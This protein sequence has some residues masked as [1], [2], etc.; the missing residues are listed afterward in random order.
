MMTQTEFMCELA[1]FSSKNGKSPTA[2][3][4]DEISLLDLVE[5]P[6]GFEKK[7]EDEGLKLQL[8][9]LDLYVVK[10][11]NKKHLRFVVD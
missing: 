1:D 4:I 2:V 5:V 7:C 8:F 6:F 10:N 9:G 11:V 3:Y